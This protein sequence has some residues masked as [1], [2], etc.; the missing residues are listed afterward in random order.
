MLLMVG[1]NRAIAKDVKSYTYCCFVRCATL[2]VRVEGMPWLQTG[3]SQYHQQL[4]LQDKGRAIK[5]LGV[6]Y[7]VW[8]GSLIYGMDFWTSASC[9][10]W[11]LIVVRMAIELKYRNTLIVSYRYISI[12]LISI[13]NMYFTKTM[14]KS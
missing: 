7:V 14:L 1:P 13:L 3:T 11:Y 8:L 10:V 2:I 6:C 12:I 9:V 5:E 4:G